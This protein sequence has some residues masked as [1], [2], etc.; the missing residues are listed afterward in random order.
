MTEP[1]AILIVDDD[2]DIRELVHEGLRGHGVHTVAVPDGTGM[3]T[4]LD[5]P[6]YDCVR[7]GHLMLG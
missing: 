7:L 6:R 1:A 2:L 5:R 4:E 3:F